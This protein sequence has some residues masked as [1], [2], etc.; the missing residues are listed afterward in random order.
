MTARRKY[1]V[2]TWKN[3]PSWEL[4]VRKWLLKQADKMVLQRN[5]WWE[6]GFFYLRKRGTDKDPHFLKA[7]EQLHPF[8][9]KG[10]PEGYYFHLAP[11]VQKMLNKQTLLWPV[12]PQFE[13]H[14]FYGLK[15]PR[16][17]HGQELV[18]EV[19]GDVGIYLYLNEKDKNI[20]E[21]KR[22]RLLRFDGDRL[23]QDEDKT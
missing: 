14:L 23:V 9:M 4:I 19:E 20:L 16:F 18:A 11:E 6:G 21:K 13:D 8:M 12:E 1:W 22:I 15:Y 3:R 7:L 5:T 10:K 17:F 2:D